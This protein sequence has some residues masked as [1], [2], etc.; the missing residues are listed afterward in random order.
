VCLDT[1]DESSTTHWHVV[2]LPTSDADPFPCE[3]SPLTSA[4]ACVVCSTRQVKHFG[5]TM[6]PPRLGLVLEYCKYG[7]LFSVLQGLRKVRDY[8]HYTYSKDVSS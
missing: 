7:D 6:D 5:V 2:L 1:V 3:A 8:H 4:G